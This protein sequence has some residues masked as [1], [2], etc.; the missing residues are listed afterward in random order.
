MSGSGRL[1]IN[2]RAWSY[3]YAAINAVLVVPLRSKVWHL[4]ADWHDENGLREYC[5]HFDTKRAMI[6]YAEE[7]GVRDLVASKED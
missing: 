2:G 5:G 6:A 3:R 7:R 4:W 1:M